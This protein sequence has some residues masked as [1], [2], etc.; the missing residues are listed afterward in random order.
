[1]GLCC[2]IASEYD[3]YRGGK[4]KTRLESVAIYIAFHPQMWY[5]DIAVLLQPT[6]AFSMGSFEFVCVPEWSIPM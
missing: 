5:S 6:P 4:L 1:V 2:T 3:I